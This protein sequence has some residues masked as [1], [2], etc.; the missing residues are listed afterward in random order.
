MVPIVIMTIVAVV[1]DAIKEFGHLSSCLV[2]QA[3]TSLMMPFIQ[4]I[5]FGMHLLNSQ[6]KGSMLLCAPLL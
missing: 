5:L 4:G 3:L 6:E 1:A 2:L